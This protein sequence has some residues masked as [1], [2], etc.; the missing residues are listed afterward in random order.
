MIGI[1]LTHAQLDM[2]R[3][4]GSIAGGRFAKSM[5]AMVGSR[6]DITVPEVLI[7]AVEKVAELLGKREQISSM[8]C[9]AVKGHVSGN[10]LVVVPFSESLR[11]V[12][13]L[14]GRDPGESAGLDEM[15]ISA[16]K[17]L[18][19]ITGGAYINAL[20]EMTALK[21][22]FSIPKLILDVP[23]DVLPGILT[24]GTENEG[25]VVIIKTA[26][27][28]EKNEQ[29]GNIVFILGAETLEMLSGCGK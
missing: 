25:Y 19:N 26:F 20:S 8:V 21:I 10:V 14:T 2:F 18:G 22:K 12:D 27:T 11:F 13:V 1:K 17:E 7:E 24:G 15:G 23:G 29:S 3:E 6:V 28:V 5:S 4:I 9:L 16:L